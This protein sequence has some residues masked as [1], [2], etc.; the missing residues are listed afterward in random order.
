MWKTIICATTVRSLSLSVALT[1]ER[2]GYKAQQGEGVDLFVQSHTLL[3]QDSVRSNPMEG[4][5]AL[6]VTAWI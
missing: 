3:A 2:I 5:I 4:M 6:K 1:T